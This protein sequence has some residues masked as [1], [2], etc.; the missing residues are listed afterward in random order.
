MIGVPIGGAT[1]TYY[2]N[3]AVYKITS[4]PASVLKKKR[5]STAY[6]RCYEAVVATIIHLDYEYVGIH[7]H[8]WL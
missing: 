6:H 1:Y 8:H 7:H 2:D 3:E 5:Y 4:E